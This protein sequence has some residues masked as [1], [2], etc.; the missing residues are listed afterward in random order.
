MYVLMRLVLPTH[1]EELGERTMKATDLQTIVLRRARARLDRHRKAIGGEFIRVAESEIRVQIEEPRRKVRGTV[2]MVPDPPNLIEHHALVIRRL[3]SEFRVVSL[4][5][6][7][8]G[9]SHPLPGFGFSLNDQVATLTAVFERLN[10]R[11][12][13]L[14][15]SCLGAFV[16]MVLTQRRPD[17]ISRLVLLQVPS[18]AE[19]RRWA[20]HADVAGL[21]ARPWLGQV[22]VQLF[23]HQIAK[24]WYAAALPANAT[25]ETR[26]RFTQPTL[27]SLRQ[28]A[29]FSLASA[30]QSLL[31]GPSLPVIQ[32][33]QPVLAIW[34]DADGTHALTDRESI[35]QQ[36]P[37]AELV[38]F[39]GCGHFPSL[40]DPK[41][42]L[43]LLSDFGAMRA[44]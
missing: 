7:G 1:H 21:I 27:H 2:V 16:G 3:A 24:H 33:P 28:G 9:F 8:F 11:N 5:F 25:A 42:Y 4:E 39:T 22:L 23:T 19:A 13:I 36:V 35:L 26:N 31:T 43:A 15:M 41:R 6:P 32:L 17:L 44:Q 37:G 10:I 12:A 40:E 29:C 18:Q 30:Y 38:T 34:G 14:E 20:R